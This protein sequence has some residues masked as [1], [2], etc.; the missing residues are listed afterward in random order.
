MENDM[1][2]FLDASFFLALYNETDVHHKKAV[3]I[4]RRIDDGEFGGTLTSDDVFDEVISVALRKLGKPQAMGCGKNILESVMVMQG[5]THLFHK[6]W[7]IFN[8]TKENFSFT[9]CMIQAIID[10]GEIDH[11]ATFDAAFGHLKIDVVQ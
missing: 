10:L 9:D 2:I 6:G 5:D 8:T 3:A 7:N 1:S 11:I 4:S